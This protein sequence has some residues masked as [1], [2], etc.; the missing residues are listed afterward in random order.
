M[1][2]FFVLACL[3][4]VCAAATVATADLAFIPIYPGDNW[5]SAPLVPFNPD[6]ASV[7]AACIGDCTLSRLDA[8]TEYVIVYDP[9]WPSEF[10]IIY[11]GDG[12]KVS[13]PTANTYYCSYEGVPDGVP[14]S[15]GIMTDMM[16]SLPGNQ[17][18]GLDAG[19]MHWVGQPFYHDT[20]ISECY[21]TDGTGAWTVEEAVS[22]GWIEGLWN[23]LDAQTQTVHTAGPASLGAYDTY[24]RT[25]HMYEI[26]THKDNLALIVPAYSTPEPTYGLVH[27][28]DAYDPIISIASAHFRFKVWG[29]ATILDSYSFTVNDGSGPIKVVAPGFSGIHNGDFGVASGRFSGEGTNRVLNALPCDVVGPD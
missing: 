1:N 5:V 2:R 20:C 25:T 16:I 21:I 17:Y 27:N 18:D 4:T 29:R 12:Y 11:L 22:W 8:P 7:F 10:G 14:D 24:L 6:P 23:Y 28:G 15:Q 26:R 3:V 9:E 13:N 19:G